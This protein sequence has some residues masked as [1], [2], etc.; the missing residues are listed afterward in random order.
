MPLTD[1]QRRVLR[2]LADRRSPESYVAGSTPLNAR[3]HRVSR[4]VDIFHDAAEE[5]AETARVD[6]AALEA[7]G[8]RVAMLRQDRTF[9]SAVVREADEEL[10]LEWAQE[11]DFRFFPVIAD[12]VFGFRLHLID[13][14]TN[15]MLAAADR[16]EARDAIDLLTIH[17]EVLPLGAVAWAAAEKNP[18]LTPAWIIGEIR[19]TA[20]YRDAEIALERLE[21]A[22]T[23]ARLNTELRRMLDEAEAFVERVSKQVDDFGLFVDADGN[24]LQPAPEEAGRTRLHHGSRKGAWALNGAIAREQLAA[25][26]RAR[27]GG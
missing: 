24:P 17:R 4:D 23:A 2:L 19:R 25:G 7:E 10:R 22:L 5:V 3:A 1:L 13:L 26:L 11:S 18:G 14:A 20:R 6:V 16:R 15:K 21:G 8:F 27:G 12:P 9:H